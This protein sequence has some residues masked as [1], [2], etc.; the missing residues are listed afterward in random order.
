V[1]TGFFGDIVTS[2]TVLGVD[3]ELSPDVVK[4][5]LGDG[6]VTNDTSHSYWLDYG[7]V[8]FFWFRDGE[9]FRASHFTV[10][11]HRLKV[12]LPF[13]YLLEALTVPLV[14]V[15]DARDGYQEYW[16]PESQMTVV[17]DTET[18]MVEKIYSSFGSAPQVWERYGGNRRAVW[19]EMKHVLGLS[20]QARRSWLEQ[21][22]PEPELAGGWFLFLCMTITAR[23]FSTEHTAK[24]EQWLDFAL[25][26][27][28]EGRATGIVEPATVA[29]NL[30]G[31]VLRAD[32]GLRNTPSADS[33]AK[34]C[35]NLVTGSMSRTD[36]NL[37]DAAAALRRKLTDT[38]EVDKW[39]AVRTD[40]P[41]A[42]LPDY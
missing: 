14:K 10:Q 22:K 13:S 28:E 3:A 12:P 21:N 34:S 5:V 37:I 33:V 15:G 29:I 11:A 16:Q 4:R 19:Q 25:W 42:V 7:F 23:A 18:T 38:S 35:L 1:D 36:K 2:G 39:L 20:P 30:A 41:S 27:W 31:L 40:I 8:E 9:E 17:V 32:V 26:A 6:F 24:R